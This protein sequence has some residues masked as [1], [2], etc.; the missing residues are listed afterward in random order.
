MRDNIINFVKNNWDK[1]IIGI[2]FIYFIFQV[3]YFILNIY[4]IPIG[5]FPDDGNHIGQINIVHDFKKNITDSFLIMGR[6]FYYLLLGNLL[7]LNYFIGIDEYLFLKLINAFF[8]IGYVCIFYKL[9]NLLNL[10]KS[11]KV[12]AFLIQT[13]LLMFVFLSAGVNYDN[14]QSLISIVI[15]YFLV[16]LFKT[17]KIKYLLSVIGFSALGVFTKM[18]MIPLVG[19]SF[20]VI[21][22]FY[23]N[24]IFP[25][26]KNKLKI[27]SKKLHSEKI[28][29]AL[30]VLVGIVCI[31]TF[32][33][34]GNNYREYN[35][36][37]PSCVDVRGDKVCSRSGLYNRSK[38]IQ[39]EWEIRK[40]QGN[41]FTEK[42]LNP[43]QYTFKW[44]GY[45]KQRILGITGRKSIYQTSNQ[46][47][48]INIL[49]WLA[50]IIFIRRFSFQKEKI[51]GALFYIFS[52]YALVLLIL[53]HYK[54]YI[55]STK[56]D[57]GMQG[58][59]L[60]PVLFIFIILLAH[61]LLNY[62]K[63]KWIKLSIFLLTAFTF[64]QQCF[65]FYYFHEKRLDY[66][67]PHKRN[68]EQ[69]LL[70]Q[71]KNLFY[72][73]SFF[74]SSSNGWMHPIKKDVSF[75][76]TFLA[77][78]NKLRGIQLKFATYNQ[79]DINDTYKFTL[80]D[81]NDKIIYRKIL[82]SKQ[83]KDLSIYSIKFTT[84]LDSKKNLYQFTIEPTGNVSKNITL[85]LMPPDIYLDGDL[86][87]QG[88]KQK[89]DIL[90][91]LL[92]D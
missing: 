37:F 27:F 3:F 54:G 64:I 55:I 81:S 66:Y 11:I 19:A 9:L 4:P 2:L 85:A 40:K 21:L 65:P 67:E 1:I 22:I 23:K 83:I 35:V 49:I 33:W 18:S 50:V 70:E 61:S 42:H 7:H 59:Y 87:I 57:I 16:L 53:V 31:I 84:I 73:G 29:K 62:W 8:S 88:K 51:L 41:I 20:I 15:I 63:N 25:L 36:L 24:F 68:P 38:N 34:F 80:K 14:L 48:F 39:K 13:N 32:G 52:I 12:L 90:F 43:Y 47:F 60:F 71:E 89:E 44:V 58:R 46:L 75:K 82:D 28:P 30:Y 79:K 76:Q 86:Y 10:K 72:K 74:Q 26:D 5:L 69:I 91:N 6:P 17:N 92:Y 56:I 45:M 77:E 78:K